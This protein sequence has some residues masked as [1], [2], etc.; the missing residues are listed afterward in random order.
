MLI[1]KIIYKFFVLLISGITILIFLSLLYFSSSHLFFTIKNWNNLEKGEIINI[2]YKSGQDP[3]E[4]Y[5]YKVY[6]IE[7]GIKV[8]NAK[9]EVDTKYLIGDNV[10]F[11]LKTQKESKWIAKE[12]ESVRIIYV[13]NKKVGNRINKTEIIMFLFMTLI[14]MLI[15]F[16]LRKTIKRKIVRTKK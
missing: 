9:E 7:T 10:L 8:F 13:N 15:Y 16:P 11:Q 3:V 6:Q 2:E 5:T 4:N 12:S 1:K 14:I